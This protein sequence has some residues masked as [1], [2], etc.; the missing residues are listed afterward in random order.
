[1]SI[2]DSDNDTRI[3]DNEEQSLEVSITSAGEGNEEALL[4]HY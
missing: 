4:K 3:T 1:M 2:A